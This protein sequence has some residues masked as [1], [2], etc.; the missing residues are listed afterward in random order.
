[1]TAKRIFVAIDIPDEARMR[2]ASYMKTLKQEFADLRVR[3]EKSE[4]LHVTVK[5][6]GNLDES[7]LA[8][9]VARASTEAAKTDPFTITISG[10][11]AFT[12]RS[13]RANVLWLGLES[14]SPNGALN[15]IEGIAAR[16][17]SDDAERKFKPH[18]TI[19]RLKDPKISRELI[20]RHLES[21]FEPV[22]FGATELVVYE[23]KL[24]PTGS[25]YSMISRHPFEVPTLGGPPQS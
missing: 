21:K 16:L 5:F 13:S 19:A 24:L 17:S 15:L 14:Y 1:M 25:V 20:I 11:G 2:V 10:T 3:W 8:S 22:E 6:A 9:L 12:K 4:K 7:D 23:S 18:L